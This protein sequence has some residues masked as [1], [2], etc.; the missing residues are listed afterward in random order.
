M[1][2]NVS[3]AGKV[4]KLDSFLFSSNVSSFSAFSFPDFRFLSLSSR[5]SSCLYRRRRSPVTVARVFLLFL[6]HFPA[7]VS[8]LLLVFFSRSTLQRSS[9][10]ERIMS[11]L[12]LFLYL[13]F[14]PPPG[15]CIAPVI[16]KGFRFRRLFSAS[17]VSPSVSVGSSVGCCWYGCRCVTSLPPP[18]L[19]L[20]AS[21]CL[22]MNK[23]RRRDAPFIH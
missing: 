10:S 16:F 1:S 3:S 17:C 6:G 21:Y 7:S 14:L 15:C 2:V 18:S 5:L 22:Q 20:C 8:R 4:N 9:F 12:P 19:Y 11:A 13:A 23:G